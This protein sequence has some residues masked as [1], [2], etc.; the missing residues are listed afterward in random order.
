[1]KKQEAMIEKRLRG[2]NL[3]KRE[4]ERVERFTQN[5]SLLWKGGKRERRRPFFVTCHWLKK[6]E[7]EREKM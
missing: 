7:R 6:R 3:T 1:M 2:F 4:G 5:I